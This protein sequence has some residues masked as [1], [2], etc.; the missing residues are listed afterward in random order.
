MAGC[1]KQCAL[2]VKNNKKLLVLRKA[3]LS[4]TQSE[5]FSFK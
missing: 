2:R 1:V 4:S 5:D 3:Q